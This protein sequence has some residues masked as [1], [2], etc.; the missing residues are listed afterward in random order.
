M[1]KKNQNSV[2]EILSDT[3]I[4]K[5]NK[6]YEILELWHSGKI[7]GLECIEQIVAL[8]KVVY[9]KKAKK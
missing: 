1:N 3:Q 5:I 6:Q 4:I 2:Q 7:T 8:E 9:F